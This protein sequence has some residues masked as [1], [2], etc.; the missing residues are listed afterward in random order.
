MSKSHYSDADK[1]SFINQL[2]ATFGESVSKEQ[3]LE[4]AEKNNLPNPHFLVSKREIKVGKMYNLNQ[5][6]QMKN[7]PVSSNS[8]NTAP[9]NV[10]P[11]LRQKRMASEIDSPIPN[12]DATYVPFGFYKQIESI[13]KSNRFYPIFITGLSGNG[14][15]TMVEQACAKLKRE[16]FRVNISIETDEDDLIGGSTLIDGN[17]T[18]REGPVL[19]AMRRGSILLIDEID[20]GSNKLLCLQ[21]I[22]EG[23][24]YFNKKTGDII[25]PSEGFNVIATA[26]TKG[27]GS[28]DGKF[29][30]AQLL[31]EAFLE[32]FPITV[33][34]DYPTSSVEKKI[35]RNKMNYFGKLDEEFADQLINWAEIIRKTFADGGIDEIIST[36]RLINIAEAYAIFD[37]KEEAINLCINRFDEDTKTA[38]LDLYNKISNP[39]SVAVQVP[40]PPAPIEEDEEIPF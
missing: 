38:F 1:V 24:P 40:P 20:R 25:H 4:H 31:D 23:K 19:Q 6:N 12:K 32:R 34:Q 9:A 22:L 18:Y 27:R 26:N 29:I 10:L 7:P 14:K 36:R 21:A 28:E 37:D 16:C 17:I 8:E 11:M 39:E 33:E 3:I 35:L 13:I 5:L 2:I 15:T 30:A